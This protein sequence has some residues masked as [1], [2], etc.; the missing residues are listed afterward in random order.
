M[1]RK[2][3]ALGALLA[4]GLIV[5]PALTTIDAHADSSV[6]DSSKDKTKPLSDADQDFLKEAAI[7]GMAE[8][9]MGKLAVTKGSRD[10]VKKFGQKMIDD[11]TKAG[12]KLT[13]LATKKGFAAPKQLDKK[14]A[15]MLD[16]LGKLSGKDFDSMYVQHMVSDHD[17]DV[18][19]FE[20]ESTKAD[21]AD[22]RTFASNTLP[23]LQGHQK[24]IKAIDAKM[25]ADE[26]K[27]WGGGPSPKK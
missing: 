1:D 12:D 23:V 4:A 26:K 8:V 11:H 17:D 18:A 25:K 7:G 14:H 6:G 20:K 2:L 15:D 13:E 10:D 19:K 9:E 24:L 21:D 16:H 27:G 3:I 5:A 22:V